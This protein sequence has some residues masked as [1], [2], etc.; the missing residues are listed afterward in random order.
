MSEFVAIENEA[1]AGA[2]EEE[3]YEL[4]EAAFEGWSPAK[5]GLLVWLAKAWSRIGATVVGQASEMSRAAFK[6]FGESLVAVPPIQA[7]PATAE[8]TWT[9]VDK[10]GYTIP[11]GTQV[12]IEASGDQVFGFVTVGDEVVAPGADK[13]TVLLQAIEPGEAANDL[14]ADPVL[15]DSLAFVKAIELDEETSSGVD[16]EEE[17]AYLNRLVEELQTLSF[18]LVIGRDFETDARAVASIARAKCLTAYNIKDGKEEALAV[19]VVPIDSDGEASSAPIKEALEA[20]QKAKLLSGINYY[21]GSPT[22]TS[23]KGKV[24][25]EVE[26]GFDSAT[27]K[28]AIESFW[29]EAFSPARWGLPTT[30]DSGSSGWVNRTKAYRLKAI[31]EI[32][33]L[34]G[35]ARVVTFEWAKGA[36]ALGTS[37]ELTLEGVA[38]LTKAGS[39]AVSSA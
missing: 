37:E 17:D 3:T 28:A 12:T 8:S 14:S 6:R 5:G 10:A 31:G 32:E 39:V 15:R 16:E 26:E 7:A 22:Y 2:F 11:S 4:L 19:S 38:P 24:V 30:G 35:V 27:V 33:R 21:V 34:G 18:S 25:F 1:S 9:M 20:R 29:A 23:I 13:A 36:G